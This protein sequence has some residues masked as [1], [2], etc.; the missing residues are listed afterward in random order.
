MMGSDGLLK[1]ETS[2]IDIHHE[3][4]AQIYKLDSYIFIK[5]S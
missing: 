1:N 2:L 5:Y 3:A 4:F